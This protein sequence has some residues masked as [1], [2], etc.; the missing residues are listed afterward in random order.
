MEHMKKSGTTDS[1]TKPEYKT[2]EENRDAKW[3]N[4]LRHGTEAETGA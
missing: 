3:R 1:G 2:E 4:K